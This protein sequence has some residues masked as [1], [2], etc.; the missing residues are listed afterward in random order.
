[1]KFM[2]YEKPVNKALSNEWWCIINDIL[3]FIR[4]ESSRNRGS[5]LLDLNTIHAQHNKCTEFVG[6]KFHR[7]AVVQ[8]N[9]T[10]RLRCENEFDRE[11]DGTRQKRTWRD[12]SA[13]TVFPKLTDGYQL[14]NLELYTWF[15]NMEWD[16]DGLEL[17]GWLPWMD[18]FS[19]VSEKWPPKPVL[20][21]IL[22]F[23]TRNFDRPAVKVIHSWWMP[24][25]FI[26][27]ILII[28]T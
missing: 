27:L 24:F 12:R 20:E 13:T 5:F 21:F 4:L 6:P 15:E 23:N 1:M 9:H 19:R 7:T 28:D 11:F 14:V 8:H 16:S 10:H 2:S 25:I 18:A 26:I 3:N 17:N 22:G